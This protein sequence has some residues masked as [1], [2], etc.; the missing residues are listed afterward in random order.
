MGRGGNPL[1]EEAP[2]VSVFCADPCDLLRGLTLTRLQLGKLEGQKHVSHDA[3]DETARHEH[4][5]FFS[6]V[7][8]INI[9]MI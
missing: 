6:I 8:G 1:L 5:F 4:V 7:I 2:E 3:L 9:V